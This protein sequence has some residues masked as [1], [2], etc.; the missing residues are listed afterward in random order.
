MWPWKTFLIC[1]VKITL[2]LPMCFLHT[3]RVGAGDVFNGNFFAALK[4]A[5]KE[6]KLFEM[7]SAETNLCWFFKEAWLFFFLSLDMRKQMESELC[8]FS[9]CILTNTVPIYQSHFPQHVRAKKN[10]QSIPNMKQLSGQKYKKW[11]PPDMWSQARRRE[12][13]DDWLSG[14]L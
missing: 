3:N 2:T 5:K 6:K 9:P 12:K 10:Y 11:N 14:S 13:I 8:R 4:L 7:T 1:S